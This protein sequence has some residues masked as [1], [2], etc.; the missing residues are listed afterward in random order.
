MSNIRNA[1]NRKAAIQ[2]ALMSAFFFLLHDHAAHYFYSG[3]CR[4]LLR[5]LPTPSS[6]SVDKEHFLWT[7]SILKWFIE[8]RR[9]WNLRHHYENY[10]ISFTHRLCSFGPTI[11]HPCHF[12][13]HHLLFCLHAYANRVL[14]VDYHFTMPQSHYYSV[15]ILASLSYNCIKNSFISWP[16][17]FLLCCLDQSC[18]PHMRSLDMRML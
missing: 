14:G 16:N 7:I 11:L 17:F 18:G 2:A 13:L 1:E 6:L 5:T 15:D 10:C 9:L 8:Y 3:S 4:F 12:L